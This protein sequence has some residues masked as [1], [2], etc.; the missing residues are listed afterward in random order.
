MKF[1]FVNG[2]KNPRFTV[3]NK[4]KHI[5]Y[6]TAFS[7]LNEQGMLESHEEITIQREDLAN[8]IKEYFLGYRIHFTLHYNQFINLDTLMKFKTIADYQHKNSDAEAPYEIFLTPNED[9]LVRRFQVLFSNENIDLGVLRSGEKIFGNKNVLFKL[10]TVQT[11]K[12]FQIFDPAKIP[13]VSFS[14]FFVLPEPTLPM[15]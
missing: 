4:N 1:S 10:K 13:L 7:E 12:D 11:Y 3:Y 14:N 15:P 5:V 9:N 8:T 2:W 6:Q